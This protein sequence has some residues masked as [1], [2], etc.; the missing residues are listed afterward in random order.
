MPRHRKQKLYHLSFEPSHHRRVAIGPPPVANPRSSVKQLEGD[1]IQ[2]LAQA[3]GGS[4]DDWQIAR[5]VMNDIYPYHPTATMPEL[6]AYDYLA[7]RKI[8]FMFQ[9]TVMGGRSVRGG[10]VPDIVVRNAGNEG[11][12]WLIQGEYWHSR[13]TAHGQKDAVVKLQML[14]QDV[15]GVRIKSVVELWENDIYHKRPRVFDLALIGIGLRG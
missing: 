5:R 3:L 15:N 2:E 1:P 10:L 4:A 12:A 8:P 13:K 9:P 14:G 11:I 7:Q 6:V